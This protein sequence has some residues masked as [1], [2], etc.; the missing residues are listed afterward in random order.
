MPKGS[1]ESQSQAADST[2]VE[3]ETVDSTV[4]SPGDLGPTVAIVGPTAVGKTSF[5][6]SLAGEL[7]TRGLGTE[8]INA[9]ALQVY[10]GLDIGTAKPSAEERA[11]VRHH[12]IDI[13][14]PD[15]LFSAGEFARRARTAL[16]EIHDRGRVALVVGGSGFYHQALFE[17][18]S[19]LPRAD[20]EVRAALKARAEEEGVEGLHAELSQV[21]P[22]TAA[23]LA[24][25]DRQ[26]VV[27]ALEVWHS[28]GLPLSAW[29]ARQPAPAKPLS[30]LHVGLTVPRPFLYDS[31]AVRVT[32][33]LER[34]WIGEVEALLKRGVDPTAAAFQAIGY[35]QLV[36]HLQ[37]ELELSE[38]HADIVR[39]T[40]RFAKRQW[41]WFRR[42]S[43]V[44]WFDPRDRPRSVSGVLEL[45]MP[46]L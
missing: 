41:T 14:E 5:A 15:Q 8:V 6:L 13:L 28:T 2:A 32:G 44:V 33:M 18:L 34:G 19:P 46:T 26:R 23:R 35:R 21:D 9:D 10:R 42:Q 12:L 29:I 16:V 30:A 11:R 24:P 3:T 17:G 36:R 38:A 37:G 40:R 27:R 22:E 20:A 39:A 25:A 4:P 43:Q 45:L 31:I 1:P 7:A